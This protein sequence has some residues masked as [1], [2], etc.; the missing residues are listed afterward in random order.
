MAVS[1]DLIEE[2]RRQ[3]QESCGIRVDATGTAG[4]AGLLSLR[5]DTLCNPDEESVVLFT[6]A[7]R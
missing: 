7:I 4:L 1:E 5:H 3:G 2:A 6:G